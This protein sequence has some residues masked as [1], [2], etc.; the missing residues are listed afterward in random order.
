MSDPLRLSHDTDGDTP[1]WGCPLT[2]PLPTTSNHVQPLS[3]TF[4]LQP[5]YY[6]TALP[7]HFAPQQQ[8]LISFLFSSFLP[9]YYISSLWWVPTTNLLLLSSL[10][11][12]STSPL[13]W[14]PLRSPL[15]PHAHLS[16][17]LWRNRTNPAPAKASSTCDL[18]QTSDL[19]PPT[20]D[21]TPRRPFDLQHH[22]RHP[23]FHQLAVTRYAGPLAVTS[24]SAALPLRKKS[25]SASAHCK[26][27]H[28]RSLGHPRTLAPSHPRFPT[29]SLRWVMT[30]IG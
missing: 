22:P 7:N 25:F 23:Q 8:T 19:R 1:R 2:K 3:T 28:P 11:S 4:N 20:S 16:R 17:S 9:P 24:I 21:R 5:L 29:S 26:E 6:P 15:A 27:I 13:W 18:P 12:H 14:T 10:H 30:T